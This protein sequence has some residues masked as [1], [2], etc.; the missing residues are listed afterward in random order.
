MQSPEMRGI[1]SH[2]K[3]TEK[4]A[5][6]SQPPAAI[7]PTTTAPVTQ[8]TSNGQSDQTGQKL[9]PAMQTFHKS[10]LTP[11]SAPSVPRESPNPPPHTKAGGTNQQPARPPNVPKPPTGQTHWPEHKKRTLAETA[12]KHLTAIPPNVGKVITADEIHN[13]LNLNPSYTQMCGYLEGR[14][15]VID[16]GSFAR[17]LLNAVPDTALPTQK[18]IERT[19]VPVLAVSAGL[20]AL[21]HA[22]SS[23][24]RQP[25]S[26]FN[27]QH[28]IEPA[29]Q[30]SSINH[31]ESTPHRVYIS[32]KVVH[33]QKPINQ[34]ITKED[35]AR[36]RTFGDIVDLTQASLDDE[37]FERH[38]PKSKIVTASDSRPLD[39][40]GTTSHGI[41]NS[42]PSVGQ[43]KTQVDASFPPTDRDPILR[44][45][46]VQ[47]MNRRRDARRCSSYDPKTI[48]RDILISSGKHPTMAPLNYH[49]KILLERFDH[50]NHD[51]DLS[52][53]KW[54]IV[55][56][57]EKPSEEQLEPMTLA[58]I[59][60]L[61]DKGDAGH[62]PTTDEPAARPEKETVIK[63]PDRPKGYATSKV[64]TLHKTKKGRPRSDLTRI[65]P[66]VDDTAQKKIV[67]TSKQ[68]G[69]SP[70]DMSFV[71]E[72]NR[73]ALMNS[74]TFNADA[75]FKTP[76]G[77][78]A[79]SSPM[80]PPS[81]SAFAR[82]LRCRT[83][84]SV[85]NGHRPCSCC[86]QAGIGARDCVYVE[87]ESGHPPPLS[88][89]A[90]SV[91]SKSLKFKNSPFSPISPPLPNTPSPKKELVPGRTGRPPGAKNRQPRSDKGISK[92]G[93]PPGAKNRQPRSDKG[94]LKGPKSISPLIA[95]SI[96]PPFE[97]GSTPRRSSTL[98]NAVSPTVGIAVVIQSR[99]PSVVGSASQHSSKIKGQAQDRTRS[100][101]SYKCGWERCPAEL[102]NLDTLRKHVR[103]HRKGVD[104][105]IPCRWAECGNVVQGSTARIQLTYENE[106]AW[107]RHLEKKHVRAVAKAHGVVLEG[108]SD[109]Q[110]SDASVDDELFL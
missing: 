71:N 23:P 46:V 58:D 70:A 99:S 34:P 105:P 88:S 101:E 17:L 14:G 107:D 27:G 85:C 44:E 28:Q 62:D 32:G 95:Q 106:K 55:N 35:K 51:S 36:K 26:Q 102:H 84:F 15:F 73:S 110:S 80:T 48:A 43:V 33:G 19:S 92:K 24:Y 4:E 81:T 68:Q 91:K 83:R 57:R 75:T 31:A 60:N 8:M 74:F 5:H 98:R 20:Q 87:N 89:G 104:L 16:R 103:K 90:N 3:R 38:R 94:I 47:P 40:A 79:V 11:P 18:S 82:C 7:P 69:Q 86:R 2:H 37:D 25:Q 45:R 6:F 49:L 66:K 13:L 96:R 42:A 54:D 93:R 61:D 10:L 30:R 29:F 108:D 12:V 59:M 77:T 100:P 78:N 72:R 21:H 97:V 50:V 41:G 52:T 63:P 22:Y 39:P 1:K 56:P 76:D 53:F 65:P 109:E 9:I 64:S 67:K